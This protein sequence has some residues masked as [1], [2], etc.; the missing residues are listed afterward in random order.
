[1]ISDILLKGRRNA[2][3]AK[4]L[5]E[6]LNKKPREITLAIEEE[7]R[8]GKPICA[9]CGK[10]PGYFL[11]ET[12]E[13]MEGYCRALHKRAGEIFKTRRACMATIGGLPHEEEHQ[14][15]Q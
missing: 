8:A 5:A 3:T 2:Q 1:M 4:E 14:R 13:E 12:R 11:A 6:I 9:S 15:R 7:R 10:N